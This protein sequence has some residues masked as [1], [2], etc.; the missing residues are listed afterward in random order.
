[1]YLNVGKIINTHGIKGEL[2]IKSNFEKKS[3]VFKPGF[4][5]YFSDNYEIHQIKT[6]RHHKE[7]EMVTI[8]DYNNIND[9]LK[10]KGIDV[11]ILKEDLNLT[12]D[13]V[14]INELVGYE[15]FLLNDYCGKII[16][17]VYNNI[18]NLLIIKK[19][20]VFYLPYQKHFIKKIDKK[21]KKLIIKNA[22][23]L[24]EWK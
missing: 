3:L 23:G 2:R 10:F 16:D 20:K 19:D 9:V 14:I 12:S 22:E 4:N 11:Y 17:F 13:E 21:N 8:D 5:L 15:V 6:Y 7:Y 18:N 1:M 24:I